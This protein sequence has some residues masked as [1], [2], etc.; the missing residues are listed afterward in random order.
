VFKSFPP[1]LETTADMK[2]V[3]SNNVAAIRDRGTRS[4]TSATQ[5]GFV[6][7]SFG[8]YR[9]DLYLQVERLLVRRNVGEGGTTHEFRCAG[10]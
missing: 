6:F 8:V 2:G 3:A 1:A 5:Q 4:W 10:A 7:V 9:G